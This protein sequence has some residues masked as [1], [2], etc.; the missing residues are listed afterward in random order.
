MDLNYLELLLWCSV[1]PQTLAVS[2]YLLGGNR[3]LRH[4]WIFVSGSLASSIGAGIVVAVGMGDLGIHIGRT[5]GGDRFPWAYITGGVL[6]IGFAGYVVWR[7]IRA[8]SRPRHRDRARAERRLERMVD[9]SWVAFGVGLMFGFPGVPY[10]LG[11]AKATDGSAWFMLG[12]IIVF[13]L[14]TTCWGWIPCLWCMAQPRK[15]VRRLQALRAAVG[16]HRVAIIAA[17][18]LIVGMY[19]V[20]FGIVTS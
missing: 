2:L 19:M 10:A 1:S 20:I 4:A 7:H 17:I 3:G 5:G 9:S 6:L 13:S 11:L 15:A 8:R 16:R 18:L 12:L 14:V